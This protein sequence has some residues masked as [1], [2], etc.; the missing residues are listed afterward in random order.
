MKEI[1]RVSEL[2]TYMEGCSDTSMG[3]LL[4][5][6]LNESANA[7][8]EFRHQVQ[9]LAEQ[10]QKL[11]E[12]ADEWAQKEAE[13]R[14]VNYV[15]EAAKLRREQLADTIEVKRLSWRDGAPK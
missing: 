10:V 15:R 2:T 13:Q 12:F 1:V 5:S 4:L 14:Y 11:I 9:V 8:Q 3:D 6:R 7:H